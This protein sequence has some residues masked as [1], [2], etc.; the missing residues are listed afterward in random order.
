[1]FLPRH[2]GGDEN[3]QVSDVLVDDVDDDLSRPL[4]VLRGPVNPGDP[5]EGL[6]GR[7]DV[8]SL[9]GE[10]DDGTFYV[11]EVDLHP[12][13]DLQLPLLQFVAHEEV[14]D[15]KFDLFGVHEKEPAPPFFEIEVALHLGVDV[16]ID[17]VLFGPD[18]VGGIKGLEIVHQMS[19]VEL[20][21]SQVAHQGN[22]PG[23]PQEP[24]P[25]AHGI[26]SL[27]PG[28]VR[29]R[30]PVEDQGPGDV[31]TVGA[32]Q[33]GGPARLAVAHDGWGVG[34]RME[35]HDLLDEPHLGGLHIT[36]GLSG[37]RLC[38]E[39][40]EIDGITVFEGHA[41]L[42]IPFGA[43]DSRSVPGPG[44]DDDYGPLGRLF[45]SPPLPAALG[46]FV[47]RRTGTGPPVADAHQGVVD[48]ARKFPPVQDHL[49]FEGQHGRLAVF[50]VFDIGVAAPAQGVGKEDGT[51]D[52]VR[53]ICP[54]LFDG[55]PVCA[56]FV[57][58]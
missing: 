19:A 31:G 16:L 23:A 27:H 43:A 54:G 46:L 2:A 39:E 47:F 44:I 38:V 8:V 26:R 37:H 50:Q 20:S 5:V 51:L 25:V 4:D 12:R 32:E 33:G 21:V 58:S 29:E 30:R 49:V 9:G 40:N 10:D 36:Q 34:V 56:G 45:L 22:Q 13:A 48:R 1:V 6:L 14:V 7:G 15:D 55:F 3:A 28:P 53:D 52:G 35:L 18:G 57:R 17:V 24:P 41:D 11:A 42:R